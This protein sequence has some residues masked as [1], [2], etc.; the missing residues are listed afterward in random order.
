MT[1]TLTPY[2]AVVRVGLALTDG[3]RAYSDVDAGLR[4]YASYDCALIS[5]V[6]EITAR[7]N[8]DAGAA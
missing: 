5:M 3:R 1:N 8:F 7:K 6:F 2:E 4:D